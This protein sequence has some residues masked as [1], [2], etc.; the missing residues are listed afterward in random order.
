MTEEDRV[1][2]RPFSISACDDAMMFGS[3]FDELEV[4]SIEVSTPRSWGERSTIDH[5]YVKIRTSAGSAEAKRKTFAGA[6]L[7]VISALEAL[8][9]L[10]GCHMKED[11]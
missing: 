7:A 2:K 10:D 4:H 6:F 3:L 1:Y 9:S 8:Q 5:C 11:Q